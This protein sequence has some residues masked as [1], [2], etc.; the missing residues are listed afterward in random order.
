M[1]NQNSTNKTSLDYHCEPDD[2]CHKEFNKQ[3]LD[4][5]VT[6][7]AENFIKNFSAADSY[8]EMRDNLFQYSMM[9]KRW[10]SKLDIFYSFFALI[11]WNEGNIR[12]MFWLWLWLNNFGLATDSGWGSFG[13]VEKI[14]PGCYTSELVSDSLDDLAPHTHYGGLVELRL[15]V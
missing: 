15:R 7:S 2:K 8:F 4:F 11:Y 10:I 3:G 1:D 9:F 12:T 13:R 14:F 5:G 6:N